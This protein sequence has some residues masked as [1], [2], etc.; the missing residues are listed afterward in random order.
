MRETFAAALAKIADLSD[1]WA[2]ERNLAQLSHT[3][4]DELEAFR[5]H[6]ERM[7]EEDRYLMAS[8]LA[9][10]AEDEPG[11][12]FDSLFGLMIEDESPAVRALAV[13]N[14]A[15]S[16]D[17]QS[18]PQ[19]LE[20]LRNDAASEVRA[21][22][23][24]ALGVYLG[25]WEGE[26]ATMEA[27]REI[28]DALLE[29]VN[30]PEE[31]ITVRQRALEAYAF[32]DDPYV[33]EVL[34]EAYDS[35]DDELRASAVFAMGRRGEEDWLPV[36]HRELRNEVE[37]IRL[38]AVCASG[39]IGSPAS[40]PYLMQV[41]GEDPAEDIRVAAIYA[42]ADFEVPEASRI[43]QDLLDSDDVAIANAADEALDMRDEGLG[44]DQMVL[45]D[46]GPP[47]DESDEEDDIS[48][49]NGHLN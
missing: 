40:I 44:E 5:E 4:S 19:V 15:E 17:E 8:A 13:G 47:D 30:T 16:L 33:D 41:I 29:V 23:A 26:D 48:R 39:E 6:W 36:I 27:R 10:T 24:A 11:L 28:G 31:E 7:S 37:S 22:A 18:A 3:T 32:S 43:L 46:Y 25:S 2:T 45:F 21:E 14:L 1:G 38:A 34:E 12:D 20:L 42:L 49:S 35:D 9:D